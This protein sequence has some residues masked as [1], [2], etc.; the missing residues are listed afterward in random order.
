MMAKLAYRF[1]RSDLG[2]LVEAVNHTP[3]IFPYA[4]VTCRVAK[5]RESS[6]PMVRK[7][8]AARVLNKQ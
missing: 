5:V 6:N 3:F 4:L 2:N 7:R 8:A 1:N